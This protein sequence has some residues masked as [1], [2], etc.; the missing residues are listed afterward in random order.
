MGCTFRLQ[1]GDV[2]VELSVDRNED[3]AHQLV[4]EVDD[5]K[6]KMELAPNIHCL[7]CVELFRTGCQ[8]K[9]D[10]RYLLMMM[11]DYLTW[12]CCD[13]PSYIEQ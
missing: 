2:Q 4:R 13:G 10:E 8:G 5:G 12:I 7:E 9:S 6:G 1:D 3:H 11:N